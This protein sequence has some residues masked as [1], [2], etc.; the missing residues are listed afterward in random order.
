MEGGCGGGAR[1][2]ASKRQGAR[3]GDE[4]QR[5]SSAGASVGGILVL[6][7]GGVLGDGHLYAAVASSPLAI[8]PILPCTLDEAI[9]LAL[10]SLCSFLDWH[11]RCHRRPGDRVCV[12][13]NF[14]RQPQ[15]LACLLRVRVRGGMGGVGGCSVSAMR[16]PERG[17][18]SGGSFRASL[19]VWIHSLSSPWVQRAAQSRQAVGSLR[20]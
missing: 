4:A 15:A 19:R 6:L 14:A 2:T 20:Y 13:V 3:G 7:E 10:Q 5:S 12:V 1:A 11:R 17:A 16:F 8:I 9:A 18:T